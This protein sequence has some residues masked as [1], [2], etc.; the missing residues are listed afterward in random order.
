ML[1]PASAFFFQTA[2]PR[3]DIKGNNR[4]CVLSVERARGTWG[5]WVGVGGGAAALGQLQA[6]HILTS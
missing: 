5:Y 4:S 3:K 1:F 6:W 2:S